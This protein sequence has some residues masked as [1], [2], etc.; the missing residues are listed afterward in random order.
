M[1]RRSPLAALL[2]LFGLLVAFLATAAFAQGDGRPTPSG[3]RDAV[4]DD[5]GTDDVCP[6]DGEPIV[7][8]QKDEAKRLELVFYWGVGCPHCEDAKPFMAELAERGV[9]VDHV[10]VR[11]SEKGRQRF[12]EDVARL[13]IEAAG[14][15]TFVCGDEYVVGFRRG[16]TEAEIEAMIARRR[17]GAAGPAPATTIELP[18]FGTLDAGA[19]SLPVFT[20][21][22]G[23]VDGIN[24]C[25]MWVLLVLMGILLHVKE[26]RR[27]ALYGGAFVLVSGI[28]YFL[29]M[30]A[31]VSLFQ[32]V[33]LSRAFTIGLGVVVVAMGL[34]N[35]KE[36]I[37]FK[38]GVSLMIP[39][40]AKPG[41]YRRMR[42]IARAA[43]LPGALLG[44]VALA[45]V[46]NLIELA[47]TLGLPAVY[48]RILSLRADLTPA[49]RYAYLVLYN[50]AYIVPLGV[51][52]GVFALTF[53]RAALGERGAKVLKAVSGAL[54]VAFGLV[55]I[56][57]PGLLGA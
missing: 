43:S 26:R 32:F 11:Q 15:P 18:L 29:F 14:V 35:L 49:G 13:G 33:G 19:V 36:V 56:L 42:A 23:L 40:R 46:V 17:E 45:F 7:A 4:S 44:I 53:R 54:L 34:I 3:D 1:A 9:H 55:F 50:L 30:T 5:C 28:V 47:C 39:D 38:K 22:V 31:W 51:I 2:A 12:L 20:V 8:P 37:W 27:I 52:V 41:L 25:A 24:P 6:L 16:A 10:E 48:T 21:A 57:A